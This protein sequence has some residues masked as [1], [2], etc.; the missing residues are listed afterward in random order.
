MTARRLAPPAL[1]IALLLVLLPATDFISNVWPLQPGDFRWRFGMVGLLS[2]FLLTPLL[3]LVL[4]A[5]AA[6]ALEHAGLLRVTAAVCSA[7]AALLVLLV[8]LFVLD[9]IQLR[10]EVT[11]AALAGFDF[12]NLRAI[13][14]HLLGAVALGWLGLACWKAALAPRA[15]SA[16]AATGTAARGGRQPRPATTHTILGG[17]A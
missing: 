12:A 11:P 4:A 13:V 9:V 15:A 3:G 2:G 8:G 10:P 17:G 16:G 14:K 6:M 5:A 1:F 7:G